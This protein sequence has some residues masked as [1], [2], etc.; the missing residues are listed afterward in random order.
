MELSDEERDKLRKELAEAE[1]KLVALQGDS[2]LVAPLREF[3]SRRRNRLFAGPGSRSAAW[4]PT[5]SRPFSHLKDLMEKYVAGQSHAMEAIA[6]SIRTSRANLS[7]PK[8]PIGV[9]LLVG[10]SGV[11]KT[12]T[13]HH[14]GRVALRRRAEHDRSSTC[15]S[16][17]RST[18]S[19]C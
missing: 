11:G 7:D 4:S 5:K 16:S 3:A 10:T 12:E 9:F 6:Q 13:A 19:R 1:H 18:R 8:T 17:R 15:R 14:A 2:P